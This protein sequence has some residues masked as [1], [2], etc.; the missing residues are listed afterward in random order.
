M[1][2]RCPEPLV[3]GAVRQS[4]KKKTGRRGEATE[5]ARSAKM[6]SSQH[7]FC[8]RLFRSTLECAEASRDVVKSPGKSPR[9]LTYPGEKGGGGQHLGIEVAYLSA[10]SAPRIGRKKMW[11]LLRRVEGHKLMQ[12]CPLKIW[13]RDFVISHSEC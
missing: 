8:R 12:V 6:R 4:K 13:L 2:P 11:Q 9:V 1:Q 3:R 10:G 7:V 5:G